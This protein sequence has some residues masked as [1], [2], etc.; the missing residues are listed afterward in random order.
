MENIKKF[1]PLGTVERLA[2]QVINKIRQETQ[3]ALN[4]SMYFS[5]FQELS[6][7]IDQAIEQDK[8][9]PKGIRN[10]VRKFLAHILVI[11]KER[12]KYTE[13]IRSLVKKN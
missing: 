10:S 3:R 13:Q 1:E 6:P 12:R 7:I 5:E 9:L 4:Q 2:I 8:G 11:P